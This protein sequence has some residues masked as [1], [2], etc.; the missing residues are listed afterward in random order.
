MQDKSKSDHHGQLHEVI[1]IDDTLVVDP[2]SIT[3]LQDIVYV[4]EEFRVSYYGISEEAFIK[5]GGKIAP[6][7]ARS[8]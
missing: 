2:S 1:T 8:D 4:P 5:K 7:A 3:P 6:R